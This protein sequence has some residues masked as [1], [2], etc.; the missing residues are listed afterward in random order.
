MPTPDPQNI[1]TKN[2]EQLI[3]V[4]KKNWARKIN[5]ENNDSLTNI[6][7]R[8]GPISGLVFTIINIVVEFILKTIFY[9][10]DITSY[11]FNWIHN[12]TF[13][14]FTGIIPKTFGGGK[15]I[16]TKFFRYTI[17]VFLPPL[18]IMLSKGMYG[19]FSILC[20]ILIT[21][22]NYLA[23]IIFAFII[24]AKNRYADQYESYQLQLLNNNPI[25][26]ENST[27]TSAFF[28][29]S[30]FVLLIVL[31]IAIFLSFF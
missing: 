8:P 2:P 25:Y 1:K 26:Q 24:T 22:V 5:V 15:V 31:S 29:S 23:G 14:N 13:G 12:I 30:G 10:F 4:S 19:W 21:Y 27:D 9:L 28:S 11:A 17:N 6:V 18:G 7:G 16:S 3:Y 20:C